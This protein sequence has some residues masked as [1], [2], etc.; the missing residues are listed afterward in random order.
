MQSSHYQKGD[1]TKISCPHLLLHNR[2]SKLQLLILSLKSHPCGGETVYTE[3]KHQNKC[4]LQNITW[5]GRE[6]KILSNIMNLSGDTLQCDNAIHKSTVIGL[7]GHQGKLVTCKYKSAQ[8][9]E[10][11]SSQSVFLLQIFLQISASYESMLFS[12]QFSL[13]TGKL[14]LHLQLVRDFKAAPS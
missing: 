7:K 1:V 9:R 11:Q 12:A 13:S 6:G 3:E 10:L 8:L 2:K 5:C 4:Y 14:L